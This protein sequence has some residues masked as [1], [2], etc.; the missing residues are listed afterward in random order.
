M[1]SPALQTI[2]REALVGAVINAGI[3][4]AINYFTLRGDGP[5]AMTVDSIASGEHTIFSGAVP[6]AVILG[7][8][9]GTISFFTFRK[10]A[11]KEG[12]AP[13]DRLDR[14]YFFWGFRKV[15]TSALV[16]FGLVVTLGV[17]WQ[18]FVGT[19]MVSTPVAAAF[20]GLVAG[21]TAWYCTT[22]AAT[23]LLLEATT[24]G[25][26]PAPGPSTSTL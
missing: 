22:A 6:L 2:R 8:I 5:H 20:T 18:R 13:A 1:R 3:N 17:L 26:E 16:M 24:P 14:P 4:G 23:A 21:V 25:T 15:L 10:K 11:L 7:F 19:V 12:L 9:V